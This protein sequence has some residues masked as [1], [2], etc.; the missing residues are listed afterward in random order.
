MTLRCDDEA[1]TLSLSVLDLVE[2]GEPS[3]HLSLDVVQRGTTRMAQGRAVHEAWAAE[4][5][6][7]EADFRAEVRLKR[8]LAVD[9]WTVVVHGRVDGISVEDGVRVIE[10][11]K[12]SALP[13]DALFASRAEHFPRWIAQ[14]ELYLWAAWRPDEAPAL[15]RLVLVSLH[16]GARHAIGVAPDLARVH[17][18]VEGRL[19]W[20]VRGREAR[21]SWLRA[22]RDATVPWT[23]PA[24]RVGQAKILDELSEA[25]ARGRP[26]LVQAP[27]GLGKTA[28]VLDAALRHTLARD[29]QILWATARTTHQQ[30]IE[31]QVGRLREAGL[32]LRAVTLTAREKACLNDRVSCR[33]EDCTFA[34]HYYDKLAE[35]RVLDGAIA[36]GALDRLSLQA[37]GGREQVCPAQLAVDLVEHADLVIGD[38]NYAFDPDIRLSRLLGDDPSGVLLVVDEVHQ[39]V[40]RARAMA[41][42]RVSAAA[43]TAAVAWLEAAGAGFEAFLALAREAEHLVLHAVEQAG[44]PARDGLALA[45]VEVGLWAELADRVDGAGLDYALLKARRGGEGFDPWQD[46]AR[47]ILRF[48]RISANAGPESVSVAQTRRGAEALR[49]ICL[50]PSV[51]LGPW[52]ARFGGFVGVSATA[53]PEAYYRDL[54]GLDRDRLA[55]IDVPPEF[56]VEN[57]AVFVAP[58]VSTAWND[59]VA[60]APRTAALL[61]DLI[62]ATPGNVAVFFSSFEM[63]QDLSGRWRLEGRELLQQT[64]GVDEDTRAAWVRRLGEPGP[65]VVLAAVLGGVFAEGIDPPTGGLSTVIVVGPALPPVGLERDLLRAHL[66]ARYGS[67]DVY[68]SWTPGL[69]KVVQA[70]GRVVRGP[71]ERGVVVLVDRR[72][73]WREVSALLPDHWRVSVPDDPAAAVAAFWGPA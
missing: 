43:A 9:G 53:R 71:E 33:P 46:L 29:Q 24:R 7:Q 35:K 23:Y 44:D 34:A 15:G 19:A 8:Q 54:I 52:I 39:L 20:L 57:R 1:R 28:A 14:L 42:P 61:Q 59:R 62:E 45:P 68:A 72:F 16:D 13:G 66:Q 17:A 27:T 3:G 55:V 4:R 63:L 41:S 37:I 64:S 2:L 58:R 22:R 5:V 6:A 12:S 36:W 56:P 73:R 18:W 69:T 47:A 49:W 51:W 38:Y 21:A 10:E 60:H 26:A 48:H 25:L 50:D 30:P 65:P 11:V 32:P 70:A 40:E 31:A 67:G